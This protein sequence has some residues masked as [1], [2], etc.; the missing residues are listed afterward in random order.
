MRVGKSKMILAA[1][2]AMLLLSGVSV[3]AQ[4][5]V[6]RTV[7]ADGSVSVKTISFSRKADHMEL[8][9]PKKKLSGI[10]T[11][12][13]SPDFAHAKAGEQGYF[14]SPDGYMTRFLTGRKDTLRAVYQNHPIAM[15][16]I[17]TPRGCWAEMFETYRF[18]LRTI[19]S[20]K[21][22]EYSARLQYILKNVEPYEDFILKIYPLGGENADYSGMGRL[23][24][25]L[26]VEGKIQPLSQRAA[27]N[28]LLGYA[29]D[30]PE[31]RIRQAW[32]PV[33]T[34]APEQNADNEPSVRVKVTFDR[35]RELVDALKKGGVGKA[36]LTLV[37]WNYKG[38]DGRFPTVFPAEITL[39]GDQALKRLIGHAQSEG[40]Q[41]VPHICTGD[42]YKVSEDFDAKDLA[43]LP[44]GE[45]D[46]KF[47]Y[48]SGRM[49]KL[50]NKVAYEKFVQSINDSL[51]VYGFRGIEYNDVYSTIPPVVC[52]NPDHSLNAKESTEYAIKILEDGRQK[53]GGIASEGGYDHVASALDFALYVS[54]SGPKTNPGRLKDEYVP[55]WHIIYNGYIFSCP[56]SQSVNYSIKPSNIGMKVIEY[57]CHPTFYFYSAH[58]DDEHNWIGTKDMDLKCETNQELEKSVQAIRQGYDYLK[59]YGYIQYLTMDRHEKIAPEVYRSSFSDGTETVCNYSATPYTYKNTSVAPGGWHIFKADNNK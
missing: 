33:P 54:M 50:C 11:L 13:I 4:K 27:E 38:H 39:G 32:K 17:K 35:C 30:N 37:G 48:G 28:P 47:I 40:Y 34:P 56:F 14:V 21:D 44:S 57:G 10:D 31:I 1:A 41:I 45:Y 52:H 16:G 19:V 9:I 43:V 7:Q 26:Y 23:Y 46:A 15:A 29:I 8:V 53:L 55:I 6:V 22:G 2:S 49:Y 36:Q 20:L 58:R 5:A 25:K 24:R 59:E 3:Q 51:R 12:E 18:D 42:S